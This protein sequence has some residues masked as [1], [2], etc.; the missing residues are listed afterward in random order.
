[1][2]HLTMEQLEAG[3]DLIR[4]SPKDK[5]VL[6]LIVR[7]PLVGAREVLEQGELSTVEGLVGDSW[8][9]RESSRTSDGS[10]H[11]DMQLNIMNSRVVALLAQDKSRWHLAGDQLFV[12]LDLSE[13]N[14]PPGTELR[15]GTAVI[16]VTDQ[17]HTGCQKFVSRFGFDAMKF[18]NSTVGRSL[19]L[20]G[21]NARVVRPGEI[22]VGD[23]VT[24]TRKA[25]L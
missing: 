6:D 23:P 17:P 7:R 4:Q 16:A 1:M 15:I 9:T 13:A 8:R 12:D 25:R 14:L 24:K 11:P 21:I 19:H 18:V 3:L 2:Q 22:R 20:R 10:P 5:G